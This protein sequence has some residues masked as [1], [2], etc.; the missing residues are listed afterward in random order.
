MVDGKMQ[1]I[2]YSD[3]DPKEAKRRDKDGELVYWAGSIA[4]EL[5][6]GNRHILPVYPMLM[7][8][9]GG[10]VRGGRGH[11]HWPG[12]DEAALYRELATLRTDAPIPQS[13][14]EELRWR[15][16]DRPAFE[17]MAAKLRSPR[18]LERLP[19]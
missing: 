14:P 2:E 10:A 7:I 16:V 3:L 12:L 9:A 5:N 1:I 19:T 13:D 15:G 4:G 11:G 6:V 18:L 8:L 17:A